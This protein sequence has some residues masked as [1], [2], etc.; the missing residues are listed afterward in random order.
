VSPG[1]VRILPDFEVLLDLW[2]VAHGAVRRSRA[3]ATVLDHIAEA[4]RADRG[5]FRHGEPSQYSKVSSRP[6]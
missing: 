5:H 1:L 4:L 3:Q 6:C 2:L